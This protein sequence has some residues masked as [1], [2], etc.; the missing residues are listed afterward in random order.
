[1]ASAIGLIA[2]APL[3][4][5]IGL[6]ILIV[7]GRPI[8]FRQQRVGFQGRPF[9][10]Y[11]FRTMVRLAERLGQPLTSAYDRRVTRLGHWLRKYKLDELPQLFNV[12]RGDMSLVGPRPEVPRYVELYS[13]EQRRV[14]ELVPGITDPA[15]I[16]FR[17]EAALLADCEDA[18]QVYLQCIM[19]EKIRLNLAYAARASI[20]TD[21][22]VILQT[23]WVLPSKSRSKT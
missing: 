12:I 7:D 5:V 23:L 2:L 21:L 3:F 20:L 4:A 6:C 22:G 1:M 19:P 9:T 10:I 18:E 15:S 11:K 17:D 14:L 16:V 13:E 8:L